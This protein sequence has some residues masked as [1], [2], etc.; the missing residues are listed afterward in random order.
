MSAVFINP[1]LYVQKNDKFTTGIIYMP[2]I[3]AYLVSHFKKYKIPLRVIDLYG[4]NP[5]KHK[6]ENNTLI[7]GEE[8]SNLNN[9]YF[10]NAE[11]FFVYANQVANH[12]SIINIIKFLKER[13]PNI[14]LVILE[15]SQAVTAYSLN[16]IKN[17]FLQIGVDYIVIGDL[18]NSALEL[19]KNINNKD[20]LK[21]ING[22]I[23]Q[24]FRNQKINFVENLNS[25]SFPA[26]D[27]FPLDNY[28]DLG[29]SHGPLSSK[30]YLPILSSRGCPYPCNF[31]VVPNTN[32]RK[33][34]SREPQNIVDEIQ[35][36]KEKFNVTEFHF[37]DLNPTVNDKRTKQLCNL[38]IQKNLKITWKIVAGT[39]VESIKNDET[40]E[41][42]SKSGCKYISIS[43]ESGSS[44]VM[45]EIQKPFNY[46][47]A[48]KTVKKMNKEKIFCQACFVIGY[49]GEEKNDLAKTK[50]M[51]FDLTRRGIDEIA[52]FIIT[53][54]PGS[55]IYKKFK[56]FENLSELTFTP[57]WRKDYKKLKLERLKMYSIFLFSKTLF[58]PLKIL[59]QIF[60]FFR[61]KFDTKMEMVPYKVLRLKSFE[62]E[63]KFKY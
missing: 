59:N 37:E 16:E 20:Y 63:K 21:K 35:Y 60:N 15:N 4:L 38:L 22:I 30:K 55:K 18:E 62:N 25:L 26:W 57:N 8:I 31:C 36:W 11:V 23:S 13:F 50:K 7:F 27:E 52:V 47:H 3:L 48:L 14:P 12:L 33:W 43:P 28:W 2:I 58:H 41:L 1:Q 46:N 6:L 5:K 39:K 51:I 24:D 49:P 34:R 42:L 9:S 10:E 32:D 29:Y 45:K 19:F 44:E 61:K 56:G 17:E 54:I 40:V 53:P